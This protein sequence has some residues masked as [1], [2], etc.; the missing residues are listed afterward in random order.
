MSYWANRL[1]LKDIWKL[2][3]EGKLTISQL[4]CRIAKRIRALKCYKEQIDTLE[5]IA[6]QFEY[7]G[8]DV[9]EFDNYLEELYD[10]GDIPIGQTP[11]K[12]MCWIATS[13]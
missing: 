11:F 9:E 10:W 1:D 6:E 3:S 4:A 7:C 12:K 8:E 13:F 2:R 5:E